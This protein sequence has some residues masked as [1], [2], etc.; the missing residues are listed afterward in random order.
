MQYPLL[1]GEP[2]T[3]PLMSTCWAHHLPVKVSKLEVFEMDPPEKSY[4][5]NPGVL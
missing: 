4:I 5:I 1:F 3:P 2:P